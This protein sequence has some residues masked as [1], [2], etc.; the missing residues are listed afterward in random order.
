MD[1][2]H[3]F[4][5]IRIYIDYPVIKIPYRWYMTLVMYLAKLFIA[6]IRK[7][8]LDRLNWYLN[9]KFER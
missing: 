9:Y 8:F 3:S 2:P 4:T 7:M 6:K 5:K 1:I